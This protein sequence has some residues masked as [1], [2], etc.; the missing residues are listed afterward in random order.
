MDAGL[1]M[2]YNFMKTMG[3]FCQKSLVTHFL[4]LTLELVPL[5]SKFRLL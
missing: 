5:Q 3:L 2:I 1:Q 4:F